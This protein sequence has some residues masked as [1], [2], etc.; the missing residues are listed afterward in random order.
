MEVRA[1]ECEVVQALLLDFCEGSLGDSQRAAVQSHLTGCALCRQA[2]GHLLVALRAVRGAAAARPGAVAP[3]VG[4]QFTEMRTSMISRQAPDRAVERVLAR[5][6]ELPPHARQPRMAPVLAA[7][8]LVIL[9]VIAIWFTLAGQKRSASLGKGLG[10]GPRT[11]PCGRL[12]QSRSMCL[13]LKT[14]S[15]P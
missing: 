3:L 6:Q 2:Q 15:R 1:L 4:G 5:V 9:T 10:G 12:K 11:N 14:S 13:W 8:A 7:A